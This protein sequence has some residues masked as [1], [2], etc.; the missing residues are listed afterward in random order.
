MKKWIAVLLALV[1]LL[2]GLAPALAYYNP[3]TNQ[4]MFSYI[5][6]P[7][8]LTPVKKSVKS[9]ET[10][11]V[12]YTISKQTADGKTWPGVT[13]SYNWSYVNEYTDQNG[14]KVEW[15]EGID[16]DSG[17]GKI[18]TFSGTVSL[19]V[20]RSDFSY[21]R[22]RM[23]IEPLDENGETVFLW[24]DATSHRRRIHH[25]LASLCY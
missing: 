6:M 19:K 8:T 16:D 7:L 23:W 11:Q 10:A 22:L 9:G 3:E 24:P 18:D 1:F 25:Q 4:E 2:T 15:E 14:Q 12:S 5:R 20:E 21:L 17:S 13:G